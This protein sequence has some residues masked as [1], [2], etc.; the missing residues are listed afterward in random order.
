M[1]SDKDKRARYDQFGFAGVDPNFG[2]GGG[3]YGGFG[4]FDFGDLGDIFGSFFGG[5]FGGAARPQ[6]PQRGESIRVGLTISLKRRPLAARR[7]WPWTAST[8]VPPVRAAA[9]RRGPRRRSA[10]SAA[11]AGRSSSG[12]RRPWA[13]SPPPPPAPSAAAGARSSTAP[14]RTATAPGGSA[15]QDHQGQRARR[16]R[17]RPDHLPQGQGNAG[18][19]GGAAGDL[20]INHRAAPPAV[21]PGGEQRLLRRAHH[22]HP[23]GAGRG[24]G[25]PYHRR[26][27]EVRHPRGDPDRHHL[28]PQGQGDPLINGRGRGD[29][30][31]TVHIETPRNLSR[32]QKE[33]LKKFSEALG[34]GNYEERK[35]FFQIQAVRGGRPPPPPS[36]RQRWGPETGRRRGGAQRGIQ[37]LSRADQR[38]K[39]A[40]AVVLAVLLRSAAYLFLQDRIVYR[41]DGSIAWTCLF[42]GG[43]SSRRRR[44]RAAGG[45]SAGRGRRRPLPAARGRPRGGFTAEAIARCARRGMTA[46]WW[47]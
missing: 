38:K 42:S 8:P 43:R 40:L 41:S 12:G 25:D 33:A 36:R 47:R 18:K 28:P 15:A 26:K 9:A 19:N 2:A 22:L 45:D 27:G 34:E 31:V 24:A 14:A 39:I 3:S 32:E 44:G 35:N 6:R 21:P 10:P 13:S 11:A 37:Q 7:R 17:Q 46:L 23:G 16:H 20:L 4:D 5:G 1:L 30:Y 29:Q